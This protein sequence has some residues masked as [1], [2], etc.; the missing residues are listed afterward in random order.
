MKGQWIEEP[1]NHL[2]ENYINNFI[3]KI[4]NWKQK[5]VAIQKLQWKLCFKFHNMFKIK[6]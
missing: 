1:Q 2:E 5:E 3:Y 4:K 6:S